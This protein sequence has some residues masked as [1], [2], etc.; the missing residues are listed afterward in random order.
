MAGIMLRGK[1][2]RN[3]KIYF[4]GVVN[5]LN[6]QQRI[7]AQGI[8]FKK[9]TVNNMLFKK[10][11]TFINCILSPVGEETRQQKR[12]G[13]ALPSMLSGLI[14]L[15]HPTIRAHPPTFNPAASNHRPGNSARGPL[16]S[17]APC[18]P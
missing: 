11:I 2:C 15:H 4:Y 18:L 1:S 6:W 7:S 3:H 12:N 13:G 14:P 16:A 10:I 8:I 5:Y 9:I 17:A